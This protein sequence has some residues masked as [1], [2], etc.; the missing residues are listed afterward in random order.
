M[1]HSPTLSFQ[2]MINNK[3]LQYHYMLSTE[4]VISLQIIHITQHNYVSFYLQSSGIFKRR[5][6]SINQAD[7]LE[8]KMKSI[9]FHDNTSA[10]SLT[11]NRRRLKQKKRSQSE[12]YWS[13]ETHSDS[14][15]AIDLTAADGDCRLRHSLPPIKKP[16]VSNVIMW[17]VIMLRLTI[18]MCA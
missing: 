10:S 9:R 3:A 14:L 13:K 2:I 8:A 17:T 1:L 11:A 4:S 15:P 18:S 6:S 16:Q 7:S 12:R 5:T